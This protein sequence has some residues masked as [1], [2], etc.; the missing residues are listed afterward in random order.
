MAIRYFARAAVREVYELGEAESMIQVILD[1]HGIQR[2]NGNEY[3]VT[4][5]HTT[6][7]VNNERSPGDWWKLGTIQRESNNGWVARH[8]RFDLIGH[9]G[10]DV[11]ELT[12]FEGF[13]Y[14]LIVADMLLYGIPSLV[15]EGL[16]ISEG[17][18]PGLDT[19]IKIIQ[20]V[21]AFGTPSGDISDFVLQELP[22]ELL[23][24][25]TLTIVDGIEISAG[26]I[27][28]RAVVRGAEAEAQGKSF[29]D[30]F[31]TSLTMSFIGGGTSILNALGFVG[32]DQFHTNPRVNTIIKDLITGASM[33]VINGDDARDVLEN[34]AI[35]AVTQ[36]VGDFTDAKFESKTLTMLSKVA[37]DSILTGRDPKDAVDYALGEL[38]YLLGNEL[39]DDDPAREID[40]EAESSHEVSPVL[41][42]AGSN[43]LF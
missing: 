28:T 20:V 24:A 16:Q 9:D 8:I 34:S 43:S 22:Q 30:A 35:Y 41:R 1:Q 19:A 32:V 3:F 42:E 13:K 38:A 27:L 31:K 23:D 15:I 36:A 25:T 14:V 29:K 4:N 6:D 17:K 26:E 18:D 5:Y 39:M 11:L 37:T 7:D 12:D 2:K 10:G 33:S 40:L 21:A